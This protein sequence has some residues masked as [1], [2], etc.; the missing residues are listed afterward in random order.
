MSVIQANLTQIL[1]NIP[2][3]WLGTTF[4][5]DSRFIGCN[6]FKDEMT[7]LLTTNDVSIEKKELDKIFPEDYVR[8]GSPLS[9][10]LEVQ[11]AINGGF[12]SHNV[13]SFGSSTLPL[14][15]VLLTSKQQVYVYGRNLFTAKQDTQ[16]KSLFG[17][18]YEFREGLPQAHADGS[19]IWLADDVKA[20]EAANVDA[21]VSSDG[22]LF[23]LNTNKV[24]I[25]DI[26]VNGNRTEGIHTIRKRLG[27]PMPTPDVLSTLQGQPLITAP[28]TTALKQHLKQLGGV[29]E[30]KGEVLLATTG[31]SAMGALIMAC[32]AY[33]NNSVDLVM[34]STAYGGSSQ[35]ADILAKSSSM[36]KH[37]F[38][39]Q[40]KSADV[41]RSLSSKLEAMKSGPK[42][43]LTV[44]Q[45]EYP[46]NPDMKDTDITG[47]EQVILDYQQATGS[48][49]LLML[50][51]TFS[52]VSQAAK[53]L[54]S[55]VGVIVFNSLSK[56]VS[57]GVTTGGSLVANTNPTSQSILA[58]SHEYLALLDTG[59]KPCQLRILSERHAEVEE[60]VASAHANAVLA[61]DALEAGVLKYSGFNMEVNFVT[62]EQIAK[63][64]TPATFSFNLPVPASI[65]GNSQ[66]TADFAQNFVDYL[67]ARYPQGSKP[68]V[69][70]GQRNSLV[71]LT[72]P[73]TST[74][75]V[76]SDEHKRKQAVGG[77][78]LVRFS[79]PPT[80][81]R[82]A[83]NE[84]IDD[85][86]R[87]FYV[88][89]T[90]TFAS[91]AKVSTYLGALAF[92]V[93]RGQ[94]F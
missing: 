58:L 33:G 61:A 48:K 83:W 13:F 80:M 47:L 23:V 2:D 56:S 16:L 82:Q 9:N 24:Q 69:S 76:I 6:A 67:N 53:G 12:D 70:F 62:K 38:D 49:V 60:R 18:E 26:N 14:I 20:G 57:G 35:Q 71:Y 34:C 31:L 87:Y 79:F 39:I 66:A 43:P 10:I 94:S 84:A 29:A 7:R 41:F 19:V 74:Q 93:V 78:Q 92:L 40:G 42:K 27:A 4:P 32:V 77:V 51:T 15:A 75:G 45:L 8:L 91:V 3:S 88:Q 68:C 81:D 90:S 85:T 44:I 28:D 63:A 59:S 5:N 36:I 89:S 37:T 55:Q 22:F 73:A 52:P 17:C 65:L 21:I 86:L 46:T 72:V 11:K 1:D 25:H 64:V 30:A 54:F 50:D